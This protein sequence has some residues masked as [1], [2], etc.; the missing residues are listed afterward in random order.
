MFDFLKILCCKHVEI[1]PRRENVS[2]VFRSFCSSQYFDDT[3]CGPEKQSAFETKLF[4]KTKHTDNEVMML[5]GCTVLYRPSMDVCVYVVGESCGNEL[6]LLSVLECLLKLL[7]LMLGSVERSAVLENI[8]ALLL[9]VD[10]IVDRGV[11]LEVD[12][13]VVLSRLQPKVNYIPVTEQTMS[14]L[15]QTAKH[16]IKWPLLQ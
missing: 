9:A 2:H 4:S 16:H 14:Q 7:N 10:E 11:V 13:E 1:F 5:E 3:F 12:A 6:M 8:D 15:M